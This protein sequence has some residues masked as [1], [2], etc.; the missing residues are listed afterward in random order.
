MTMTGVYP[1]RFALTPVDKAVK[2]FLVLSDE[3]FEDKFERGSVDVGRKKAEYQRN[4]I[5]T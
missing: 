2:E 3:S 1:H 4:I 5:V